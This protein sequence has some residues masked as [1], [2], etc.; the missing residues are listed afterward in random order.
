MC[1]AQNIYHERSPGPKYEILQG[2]DKTHIHKPI[3]RIG[4]DGRV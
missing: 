1:I 4:T 2:I 3:T